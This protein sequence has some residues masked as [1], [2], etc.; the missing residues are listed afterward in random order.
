[1]EKGKSNTFQFASFITLTSPTDLEQG[2]LASCEWMNEWMRFVPFLLPITR[3]LPQGESHM[4]KDKVKWLNYKVNKKVRLATH[5]DFNP[6]FGPDLSFL[7]QVSVA[8]VNA[9]CIKLNC[10]VQQCVC[11]IVKHVDSSVTAATPG[12][13]SLIWTLQSL[14]ILWIPW[15][16]DLG[17]CGIGCDKWPSPN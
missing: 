12:R 2:Q 11:I 9:C 17:W 4:R 5:H 13:S 10:S 6:D 3:G 8:K 16:T 15:T 1:M 7:G 14:L